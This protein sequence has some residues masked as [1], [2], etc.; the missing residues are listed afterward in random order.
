MHRSIYVKDL[1]NEK[2]DII[3]EQSLT[4]PVDVLHRTCRQIIIDDHV[5]SF[6]VNPSS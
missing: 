6:E 5:H 2:K 4:Y 1:G 3:C